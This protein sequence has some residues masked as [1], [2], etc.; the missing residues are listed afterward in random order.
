MLAIGF[1]ESANTLHLP[2]YYDGLQ[3]SLAAVDEALSI[4]VTREQE[5]Q[6]RTQQ[7]AAV[8]KANIARA[9]VPVSVLFYLVGHLLGTCTRLIF[10]YRSVCTG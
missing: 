6:E 7:A 2:Q 9:Q 10:D 8:Q 1:V 4:I 3:R 5:H